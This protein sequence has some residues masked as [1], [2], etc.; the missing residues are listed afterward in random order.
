MSHTA[1]LA[2]ESKIYSGMIRQAG[3]IE[4]NTSEELF[5]FAKAFQQ[6]LPS[7]KRVQIITDGGGFGVMTI[8]FIIKNNLIP[9]VL[10]PGSVEMIKKYVPDYATIGNPIDLTGDATSKRYENVLNVVMQDSNVDAVIV[11]MLMQISSLGSEI[12]DILKNMG[13]YKKPLI[14]CT[15]GS[16]FTNIHKNILEENG[17]PVYPTPKR[18]VK[19]LKTLMDY[20]RYKSFGLQ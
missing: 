11:I 12:V 16:E 5:D 19:S 3:A 1:S 13:R 18:A 14:I 6:P 10:S 4:A 2:G 8:D 20:S 7:G 17:M 15:T 9:S